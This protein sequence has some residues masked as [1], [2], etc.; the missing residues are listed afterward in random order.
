MWVLGWKDEL[1]QK[2]S[3]L[4]MATRAPPQDCPP[5][6]F[7]VDVASAHR[8]KYSIVQYFSMAFVSYLRSSSHCILWFNRLYSENH[9]C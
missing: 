2:Q 1:L 3:V 5:S 9:D 6:V 4:Y 7:T 8:W